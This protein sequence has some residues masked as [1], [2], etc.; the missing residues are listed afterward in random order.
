MAFAALRVWLSSS[1]FS[2]SPRCLSSLSSSPS[3]GITRLAPSKR[4][5]GLTGVFCTRTVKKFAPLEILPEALQ[6]MP[7]ERIAQLAPFLSEAAVGSLASSSPSSSPEAGPYLENLVRSPRKTVSL[8]R[9]LALRAAFSSGDHFY[10]ATTGGW[11]L[12]LPSNA[13]GLRDPEGLAAWLRRRHPRHL[14]ELPTADKGDLRQAAARVRREKAAALDRLEREED[15]ADEM[16]ARKGLERLAGASEGG[17]DNP[18]ASSSLLANGNAEVAEWMEATREQGECGGNVSTTARARS[19]RR[20][21]KPPLFIPEAH[22]F[23][24]NDGVPWPLPPR[25]DLAQ[26]AYWA[27]HRDRMAVY[28]DN[29]PPS[30]GFPRKA[31]V[32]LDVDDES[33]LVT[34]IPI[35]DL[36]PGDELLLHY[37]WEWWTQRLLSTL[38][39]AVEDAEMREVREIE[40]LCR[41]EDETDVFE[42]FPRLL[43]ARRVRRR[44]AKRTPRPQLSPDAGQEAEKGGSS[45]ASMEEIGG[46]KAA[47]GAAMRGKYVLYNEGTKREATDAAVLMFAV[48]RSC[49]DRD[50]FK[51]LMQGGGEDGAFPPVFRQDS[52]DVEVPIEMIR[53]ALLHF[54]RVRTPQDAT[55]M[56]SS[57]SESEVECE[58]N[59]RF[60]V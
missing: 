12:L 53:R 51:L 45:S 10:I 8:R 3:F 27:Q 17:K 35:I 7:A 20:R 47:N 34:L 13:V 33:G 54:F 38:L 46:K 19:S 55:Q 2:L 41:S 18:P 14:E 50:F 5:P 59:E 23:Q 49:L 22:L 21:R 52:C 56:K 58:D 37:S 30:Q 26:S 11:Y 43:P 48:R 40:R 25:G 29:E 16:D 15:V 1:P 9:F 24:I 36:H 60:H 44:G 39:L 31:N 28:R 4:V 32:M 57:S 6:G 42:P